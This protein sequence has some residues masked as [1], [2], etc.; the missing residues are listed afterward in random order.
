MEKLFKRYLSGAVGVIHTY[1][2]SHFE[3]VARHGRVDNYYDFRNN[4]LMSYPDITVI[5]SPIINEIYSGNPYIHDEIE[6]KKSSGRW[7]TCNTPVPASIYSNRCIDNFFEYI[8]DRSHFIDGYFN[9]SGVGAI[10][11]RI[12]IILTHYGKAYPDLITKNFIDN[13]G[14]SID[15]IYDFHDWIIH[16]G[17]GDILDM[18][19]AEFIDRIGLKEILV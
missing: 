7:T 18:L 2:T 8:I 3:I 4:K 19:M 17:D 9:G 10:R 11:K 16:S 6:K 15:I 12:E 5:P 13:I 14:N 1:D